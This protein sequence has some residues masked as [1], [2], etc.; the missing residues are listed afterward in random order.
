VHGCC[1]AVGVLPVA[2]VRRRAFCLA[3][4]HFSVSAPRLLVPGPARRDVDGGAIPPVHLG[5]AHKSAPTDSRVGLQP[6]AP[7]PEPPARAGLP[8]VFSYAVGAARRCSATPVAEPWCRRRPLPPPARAALGAAPAP[9]PLPALSRCPAALP[10]LSRP[11]SSPSPYSGARASLRSPPLVAARS[12]SPLDSAPPPRRPEKSG[13]PCRRLGSPPSSDVS[14]RPPPP[15]NR[16]ELLS[17]SMGSAE[18]LRPAICIR[19]I[20]GSRRRLSA[21]LQ[22]PTSARGLSTPHLPP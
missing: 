8:T 15:A 6:P 14:P 12:S 13:A 5:L 4:D 21:P 11:L 10:P 20:R 17:R 16:A 19:R 9:Y 7:P 1:R 2:R 22:G 3:Y 18:R